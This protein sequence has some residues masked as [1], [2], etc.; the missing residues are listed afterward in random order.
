MMAYFDLDLFEFH[1]EYDDEW[2]DEYAYYDEYDYRVSMRKT[3]ANIGLIK[4]LLSC[5]DSSDHFYVSICLIW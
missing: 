5:R 3:A 2:F 4:R 1:D